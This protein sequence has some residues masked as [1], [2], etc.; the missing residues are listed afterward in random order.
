VRGGWRKLRNEGL[1]DLYF[2]QNNI[3]MIKLRRRKEHVARMGEV[4]ISYKTMVRHCEG[5]MQCARPRLTNTWKDNI[6]MNLE[7]IEWVG[8]VISLRIR[9]STKLL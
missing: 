1:H 6:E 7:E 8:V 4:S 5:K 9:T 3:R 2:T